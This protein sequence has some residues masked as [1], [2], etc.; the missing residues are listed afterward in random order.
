MAEDGKNIKISVSAEVSE[1]FSPKEGRIRK[2][3]KCLQGVLGVAAFCLFIL[4][5]G[6]I[7]YDF[8]RLD[9]GWCVAAFVVL[10][11]ALLLVVC[12]KAAGWV[13]EHPS[14]H[15]DGID[16]GHVDDTGYYS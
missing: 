10:G 5:V 3:A 9:V 14:F 12:S 1:S 15:D 8:G 13:Y 6:M 16:M 11:V 2:V 4:F 7:V